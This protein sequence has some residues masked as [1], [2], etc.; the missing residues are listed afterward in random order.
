MATTSSKQS[1][2]QITIK[3]RCGLNYFKINWSHYFLS[4]L[5]CANSRIGFT[6]L[7]LSKVKVKSGF[8]LRLSPGEKFDC[9][10]QS[11]LQSGEDLLHICA[12][13]GQGLEIIAKSSF[14]VH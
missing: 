14:C 8:L 5:Y 9:I 10:F 13:G 6:E 7:Q 12:L 4:H 1:P 11:C 2:F 3:R